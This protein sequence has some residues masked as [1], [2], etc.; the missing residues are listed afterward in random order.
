[1]RAFLVWEKSILYDNVY[2][3]Y[4]L[5]VGTSILK[6]YNKCSDRSVEVKFPALLRV[7][8]DRPND[9]QTDQPTDRRTDRVIGKFHFQKVFLINEVNSISMK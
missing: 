9:R 2:F 7:M 8:T 6:W 5:I 4:I 3:T 1:M